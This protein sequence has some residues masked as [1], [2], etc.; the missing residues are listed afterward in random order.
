MDRQAKLKALVKLWIMRAKK[1]GFKRGSA[2][3][4]KAQL[5]FFLGA[6]ALSAVQG[7]GHENDNVVP[8]MLLVVISV[9]RDVREIVRVEE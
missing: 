2:K 9:G 4:A 3:Y 8:T 6:H 7:D 1:Q 5:E